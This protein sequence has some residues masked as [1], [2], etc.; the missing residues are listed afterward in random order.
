M[1]TGFR[2]KNIY[3]YMMFCSFHVGLN[4]SLFSESFSFMIPLNLFRSSLV[5]LRLAS[6]ATSWSLNQCAARLLDSIPNVIPN[7]RRL[8]VEEPAFFHWFRQQTSVVSRLYFGTKQRSMFS[9]RFF[10]FT[11]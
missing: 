6:K 9:Q 8:T 1:E 7:A 5:P 2:Y 10:S 11:R 4:R 3:I